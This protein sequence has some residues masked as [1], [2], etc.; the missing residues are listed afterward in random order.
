MESHQILLKDA[1]VDAAYKKIKPLFDDLHTSFIEE[2]LDTVDIVWDGYLDAYKSLLSSKDAISKEKNLKFI[3][4]L[5]KELRK[6]ICAYYDDTAIIWKKKYLEENKIVLKKSGFKILTEQAILKVLLI[7]HKDQ[8]DAVQAIN[9]FK[10][11]FTYFSGYNINRENYYSSDDSDTAIANRIV[12]ENLPKFCA[13]II[14]CEKFL[15]DKKLIDKNIVLDHSIFEINSFNKFLNQKGIDFYNQQIDGFIDENGIKEQGINEKINL[16]NQLHTDSKIPQLKKLYKQIGGKVIKRGLFVQVANPAE[17]VALLKEFIKTSTEKNK[18]L[19]E[20]FS[21]L[22]DKQNCRQLYI[23]K[24]ALNTISAKYFT[25]WELLS[26]KLLESKVLKRSK[27]EIKIPKYIELQNILEALESLNEPPTTIFKNVYSQFFSGNNADIFIKIFRFEMGALNTH[28]IESTEALK[29]V[30]NSF[31][32]KN[33]AQ[34]TLVKDFADSA[35]N[36]IRMAKYFQVKESEVAGTNAHFYNSL[37]EI[38]ESYPCIKWY[39]TIRNFLTKKPYNQDKLKLN[40]E[41]ATL[42]G[43]WDITKESS[44]LSVILKDETENYFLAISSK[45]K[46][47]S[48]DK[49]KHPE[50]YKNTTGDIKK[51][52]FKLL[53]NPYMELP[54]VF[55]SKKNLRIFN[56]SEDILGIKKNGSF[57]KESFSKASLTNWIDFCKKG[58]SIYPEWQ[59]FDFDFKPSEQYEDVSQFYNDVER[60]GYKLSFVPINKDEIY[61][62]LAAVDIYLFQIVNKDLKKINKTCDNKIN[63]HTLYW[64]AVFNKKTSFKLNGEAEVFYRRAS[65]K[66]GAHVLAKVSEEGEHEISHA[67]SK[68]RYTEDK[69]FFHVPITLNFSL[70]DTRINEKVNTIVKENFKGIHVIGI[71]R[72]E[73]HLAYYTVMDTSGHV[74]EQGSLNKDLLGKDYAEKL[75]NLSKDRDVARKSWLEIGTIKELKEGYISQAIKRIADLVIKYNAFIVLEDLNVGFMRGRQKIE[76]SVYQKFELALA[77]KLNY[78]TIKEENAIDKD[79]PPHSYQLTPPV[80][81]FADIRGKQFGVM[82]YTR[83]NYTSVTDPTT[84]FRK[85]IYIKSASKDVMRHN[86]LKFHDIA[87]D[88]GAKAYS[89]KY[90]AA[91]FDK[92]NLSKESTIWSSVERIR[93]E[94]LNTGNIFQAHYYDIT[95]ELDNLF[96]EYNFDLKSSILR[97]IQKREDLGPKFYESLIFYFN[98]IL[99]LR[100]S[101]SSK[102]V[103]YIQSPVRNTEGRFFDS[104]NFEKEHPMDILGISM[105]PMPINGD[106]NG[107]YN[108]ARK[109]LAM[110]ER[111]KSADALDKPDLYIK[112]VDWDIVAQNWEKFVE[113]LNG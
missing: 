109:G 72:G 86:I 6:K 23:T 7:I 91:D 55:F 51:M 48:F 19:L 79:L 96:K 92:N 44:N 24:I 59:V 27:G 113:K 9:K 69:F 82:L 63:L 98:L 97:Q 32:P 13:N 26:N 34:K 84:G 11:F 2:S 71:D 53:P 47:D 50:L 12:D 33:E 78:L 110:L 81:T 54:K 18:L 67:F 68:N 3:R 87:F 77:K 39:D 41:C 31:D 28:H 8:E 21:L 61:R 75:T 36:L 35:L 40:F 111:I 104:R 30:I 89:F 73:K 5:S 88:A 52:E 16:Y 102:S 14:T 43:G 42:L 15:N 100:N 107:S 29:K 20:L 90:N 10:G 38:L 62:M 80:N 112:D 64:K 66:K 49:E 1:E 37:A 25:N 46:K 58:L 95:K 74:V 4:N 103:D 17:L 105:S 85:N 70:K 76:K 56:P 94:R 99:Q 93:N 106:S 22:E 65:L 60:Q 83:A 57:K 108:I 101:D 45:N